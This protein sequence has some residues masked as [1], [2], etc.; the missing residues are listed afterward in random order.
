MG[1]PDKILSD[2]E[3]MGSAGMG[4]AVAVLF[5]N[6]MEVAKTRLQMQNE[7]S[8]DKPRVYGSVFDVL[9]KTWKREGIRGV[10]RGLTISILR[11]GSK[12]CFRL[13]L[14]EPILRKDT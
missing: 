13:G 2:L 1:S 4:A 8:R 11:D 5:S 7:L 9:Q 12:C 6:P 10:Q 14:Y 3:L